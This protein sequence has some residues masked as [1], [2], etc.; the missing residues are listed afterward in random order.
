MR[1]GRP[2]PHAA[3]ALLAFAC[4]AAD[5]R[6]PETASTVPAFVPAPTVSGTPPPIAPPPA[7]A[8]PVDGTGGEVVLGELPVLGEPPG[9]GGETPVPPVSTD[10]PE[11]AGPAPVA[12]N[13]SPEARRLLAY[14]YEQ[15]GVKMLSGQ[16]ESTWTEGG[17]D[18]EIDYVEDVTGRLPAVRGLDFIQYNGVANRTIEWWQRGGIANVRWHWGAPTHGDG[19]DASQEEVDI[20]RVLTPGTPEYAS[21]MA[22]LDRAAEELALMRDANV[23]VLWTPFHELNGDWFWWGK[24]GPAQFVRLWR[25]MFEYFNNDK[26]LNNLIWVLGYTGQPDGDWYPGKEFVDIAGADTYA[27]TEQPQLS[28]FNAVRNIVGNEMPVTFHECGVIPSPAL[29]RAEGATWSWFMT[30]HTTW[31]TEENTPAH[32]QAVYADDYVITL[33]E[34][35]DLR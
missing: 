25:F 34:L 31:L 24:Q 1:F 20:D 7:A 4:G 32:L 2:H 3:L 13:A 16:M 27:R 22:G 6:A 8:P 12:P 11:L 30:W 33:D 26:G 5:E 18:Y 10:E 15:Y 29:A 21:M 35:P 17:A 19:Y 9:E 28:M 14:L 23:P